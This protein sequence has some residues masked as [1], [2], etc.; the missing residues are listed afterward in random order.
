MM[1]KWRASASKTKMVN[2][3][4]SNVVGSKIVRIPWNTQNGMINWLQTL[5]NVFSHGGSVYGLY[6]LL[7]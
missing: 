3:K 2:S 4:T 7:N 6:F 1:S 5:R